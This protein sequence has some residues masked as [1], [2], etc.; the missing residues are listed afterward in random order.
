[1]NAFMPLYSSQSSEINARLPSVFF[2]PYVGHSPGLLPSAAGR[3]GR[4]LTAELQPLAD[5]CA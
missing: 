1:M 4:E 5:P 3:A 2:F